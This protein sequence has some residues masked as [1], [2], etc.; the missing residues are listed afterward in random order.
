[1]A[2]GLLFFLGMTLYRRIWAQSP[3]AREQSK[4]I[5]W[6]IVLGFAPFTIW[7]VG[8]F[9]VHIPTGFNILYALPIVIFPLSIAYAIVRYRVLDLDR[10][11]R[12]GIVYLLLTGLVAL[13]TVVLV[14]LA[15]FLLGSTISPNDPVTIAVLSTSLVV[16][17]NP[18][19]RHLQ[20][21]VDRTFYRREKDYQQQL[22]RFSHVLTTSVDIDGVA[23]AIY[24]AVTRSLHPQSQMIYLFDRP[25]GAYLPIQGDLE[26]TLPLMADFPLVQH[27]RTE[28]GTLFLGDYSRLPHT[29]KSSRELLLALDANLIVPIRGS[30][31]L[32]GLLILGAAASGRPYTRNEMLF[33]DTMADQAAVALERAQVLRET[34]VRAQQLAVLN[35]ASQSLISTLEIDELLQLITENAVEVL[36]TEAGS[37]LLLNDA[38]DRLVFQA[39]TGPSGP[40]LLGTQIPADS[41]LAGATVTTRE[42]II[43]NDTQMDK[44]W[45]QEIDEKTDFRTH[46]IL[47]VPLANK[48]EVIGVLE[49]L[50]KRN[51]LPF[52]LEDQEL[53]AAFAAQAALA[54]ENARLYTQT[55]QSLAQ[56]VRE[57]TM[58]QELDR[59][60]NA[61]LDID[62]VLGLTLDWV[63]RVT[64]ADDGGIGMVELD[65][66]II[67][68]LLS[69]RKPQ[70]IAQSAPVWTTEEGIVGRVIRTASPAL[71]AD[72][73]QD[74]DYVA[75]NPKTRCQLTVPIVREGQVIGIITAESIIVNG[76]GQEELETV[77]RVADHAAVAIENARLY[78]EVKQA[79]I[80]KSEFVSLVSHELKTPMTSIQGYADLLLSGMTRELDETQVNFLTTIK[81]N[82]ERMR[83]QVS[84][85]AD[86]SHMATGN[87]TIHKEPIPF[88]SVVEESLRTMRALCEKKGLELILESP[89]SLPAIDGDHLRLVQVLTNLVSNAYK[90]TPAPGR[91]TVSVGLDKV[92]LNG[93]EQT[94][95]IVCSV[96]D[97]GVGISS[98]DQEQL[99]SKFFRSDNESVRE[100]S[101][102]GLGLVI[103]KSLVEM[104]KGRVWLESELGKG[105]TFSFALPHLGHSL[106]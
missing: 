67:Q 4:V 100:T 82:V 64:N 50:N 91:I 89:A 37:L 92:E 96:S 10:V 98:E 35:Q 18:L 77:L 20:T 39:A 49:F 27:L 57:L 14:N 97:T 58:M 61:T 36:Q 48:K 102:T 47:A 17:F 95:C 2:A 11:V 90:Y 88:V 1:M 74:P 56:R 103:T 32:A 105:S 21:I 13:L 45:L 55:D 59:A 70:E 75:V 28:F 81:T 40:E 33:L 83:K 31:R 42:P 3:L 19:R 43:S 12:Q 93:Q 65:D 44:R 41:G 53:A 38:K 9:F 25:S 66:Q 6:G 63:I 5:L 26:N 22:Q 30:G 84:D 15:G 104:H 54:I 94:D 8:A 46:S 79:N 52:N 86:V 73:R 34:A 99:F 80:A 16:L 76:F 68:M 85:L 106:A 87:L 101:G 71:V 62:R 24:A 60:L 7:A 23:N 29:L 72:V 69:K 51:Q 78:K